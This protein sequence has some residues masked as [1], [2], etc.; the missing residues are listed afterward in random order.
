MGLGPAAPLA[1]SGST[2]ACARCGALGWAWAVVSPATLGRVLCPLAPKPT[3]AALVMSPWWM[4]KVLACDFQATARIR[5][6]ENAVQVGEAR[7]RNSSSGVTLP[8]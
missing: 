1:W 7:P 6:Q 2:G 4:P 5:S 3:R 8:D